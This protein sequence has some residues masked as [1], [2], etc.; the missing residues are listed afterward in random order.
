MAN[1]NAKRDENRVTVAL[2][3]DGLGN[4]VPL[5]VDPVTGRLLMTIAVMDSTVPVLSEG[6]KRDENRVTTALASDGTTERPLLIENSS[7]LLFVDVNI[8]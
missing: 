8:E 6:A 1:T 4:T 7:G 3:S 5:K 2:V